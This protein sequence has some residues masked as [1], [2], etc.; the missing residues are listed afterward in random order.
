[1]KRWLLIVVLTALVLPTGGAMAAPQWAQYKDVQTV[2]VVTKQSDGSA[3]R[4]TVWIVVVEGQAYLRTAST[5]WGRDLER[6]PSATLE[7]A[8]ESF[9]VHVEFVED[10][11]TR[12]RVSRAFREKYGF[13][14]RVTGLIR[15]GRARILR[16]IPV[17]A[18]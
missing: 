11:P 14:D 16:L 17:P 3:R 18:R 7:I 2:Q 12:E 9:P 5:R 4:T 6:E 10:D 15:F 8:E 1:M 13:N